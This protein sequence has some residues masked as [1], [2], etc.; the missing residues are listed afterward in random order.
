M[1]IQTYSIDKDIAE[2]FKNQTPKQKTSQKLE[3]L[4]ADYLDESV[5]DKKQ[6]I[7]ILDRNVVTKK[8]RRL[9]EMIVEHEWFRKTGPQVFQKAKSK[10]LYQG[11]SAKHHF[12]E[13]KKFISRYDECPISYGSKFKAET[14]ECRNLDCPSELTLLGL[15]GNDYQCPKCGRRYVI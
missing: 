9:V 2:K 10:G 12:K 4:M 5:E 14:F 13:A 1:A 11:D 15:K 6:P 7:K 3:E 8:R